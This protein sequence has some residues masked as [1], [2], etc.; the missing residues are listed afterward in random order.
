MKKYAIILPP[1]VANTTIIKELTKVLAE[2]GINGHHGEYGHNE[3]YGVSFKGNL[4]DIQKKMLLAYLES[5]DAETPIPFGEVNIEF[6]FSDYHGT[7]INQ[8]NVEQH[9]FNMLGTFNENIEMT[10]GSTSDEFKKGARVKIAEHC[11]H[12]LEVWCDKKKF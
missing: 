12:L 10:I 11:I 9:L 4:S 3:D 6:S 8:Y 5:L 7:N 1:H 2:L